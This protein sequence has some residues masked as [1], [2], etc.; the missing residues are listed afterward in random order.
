VGLP[1]H[2]ISK[3]K[4]GVSAGLIVLTAE[5][6]GPAE[7]A[8]VL[9][10]DVLLSVEGREVADV[11]DLQA[12]LGGDAVGKTVKV[13]ILRGGQMAEASIVVGERPGRS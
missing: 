13:A 5:P 4:L 1:E 6:G 12:A 3:L 8:G 2:L 11:Q 7:L 10:G 9:V